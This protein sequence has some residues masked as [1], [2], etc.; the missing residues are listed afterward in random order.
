MFRWQRAK[1]IYYMHRY[2]RGRI[3]FVLRPLASLYRTR[4]NAVQYNYDDNN[5]N[6]SVDMCMRV[7]VMVFVLTWFFFNLLWSPV[8]KWFIT[9]SL[10][11][12]K[13]FYLVLCANRNTPAI[14]IYIYMCVYNVYLHL[15]QPCV[16]YDALSAWT[17]V[18]W[19]TSV[20]C[21]KR[22]RWSLWEDLSALWTSDRR[23]NNRQHDAWKFG[24]TL[25]TRA[26]L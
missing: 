13:S 16:Q 17:N 6:K 9:A 20:L 5:N 7:C 15:A 14:L 26:R 1:D 25:R 4:L 21:K 22:K 8:G 3:F 2:G 24:A 12:A 23:E 11:N 19:P 10:Y 18:R